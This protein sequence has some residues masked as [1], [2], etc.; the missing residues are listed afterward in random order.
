ILMIWEVQRSSVPLFGMDI[1]GVLV[2]CSYFIFI[3]ITE[4]KNKKLR[5][6]GRWK[7]KTKEPNTIWPKREHALYQISDTGPAFFYLN[8]KREKLNTTHG[9]MCY[10]SF[11]EALEMASKG[12]NPQANKL[13]HTFGNYERLACQ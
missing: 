13:V 12:D 2:K 3:D 6:S 5:V 8:R 7:P 10:R 9:A 11:E 4:S 1:G